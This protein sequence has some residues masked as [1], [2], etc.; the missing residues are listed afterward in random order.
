MAADDPDHHRK[1]RRLGEA[2]D[3]VIDARLGDQAIAEHRGRDP[4]LDPRHDRAPDQPREVRDQPQDRQG[5]DD[6]QHPR[7]HQH[8]VGIHPQ[9]AHRVDFLAH[10][11]RPDRGRQRRGGAARDDD[12]GQK[13]PQLAQHR[14]RDQLDHEHLGAEL[15]KLHRALIGQHDPDQ[16]GHQCHDRDRAQPGFL[17]VMDQ[18]GQAEIAR[19]ADGPR[20]PRQESPQIFR[21]L[22]QEDQRFHGLVA[23]FDQ[24]A[25]PGGQGGGPGLG[26]GQAVPDGPE[27]ARPALVQPLDPRPPG[28]AARQ[29][30]GPR[31]IQPRQPRKLDPGRAVGPGGQGGQG[32]DG[33]LARKAQRIAGDF[34]P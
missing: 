15:A 8:Q 1:D 7:D 29:I 19:V 33:E 26:L 4:E 5:D 22:A 23:G 20:K 18:R 10:L 24:Q 14:D 28:L 31:G 34:G 12:R 9:R 25:A 16:E 6:R 2:D 30:P 13:D 3:G 21:K 27:Q 17:A 32:P 11:H